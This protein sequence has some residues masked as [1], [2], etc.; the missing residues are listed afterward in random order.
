MLPRP[1]TGPA[2]EP[3]ER[4]ALRSSSRWVR[5]VSPFSTVTVPFSTATFS[6]TTVAPRGI[7]GRSTTQSIVPSASTGTRISGVS[8]VIE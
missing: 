5:P 1:S 2:S 8:T 7:A 3:A 4:V 6:S